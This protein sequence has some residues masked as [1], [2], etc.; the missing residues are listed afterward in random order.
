MSSDSFAEKVWIALH[1][2]FFVRAVWPSMVIQPIDTT[3]VVIQNK[4][5]KMPVR[6]KSISIPSTL[7]REIIHEN[8]VKGKFT[9]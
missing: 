6:P 8:G 9:H 2:W 3:K 7:P 4:R 1:Y 5:G